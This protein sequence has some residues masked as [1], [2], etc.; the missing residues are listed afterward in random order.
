MARR[1]T[2][3]ILALI[4]LVRRPARGQLPSRKAPDE[5][6]MAKEW[7]ALSARSRPIASEAV[8]AGEGALRT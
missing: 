1:L 5:P 6:A 3:I 7:I 4:G 2:D 8:A